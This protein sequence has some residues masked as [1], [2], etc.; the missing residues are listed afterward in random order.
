EKKVEELAEAQKRTEKKVEEL[1]EAQKRTEKKVEELA[2]AQRRTEEEV[3]KLAIALNFTRADLGGLSKTMSYAFE[4][5]AFRV[6]PKILKER[7]NIEIK[8]RFIRQEIGGKEINIFAK[9]KRDGK[10]I[11]ILGESKLRIGEKREIEDLLKEIEDKANAVKSEYRDREIVKILITHYATKAVLNK[12]K[13]EGVI[14]IQSF[15]F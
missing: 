15:E 7:F 9:G 12:A 2:E 11:L 14:L 1:A 10:D 3:R 5:E 13:K 6:L 4:N 8:E